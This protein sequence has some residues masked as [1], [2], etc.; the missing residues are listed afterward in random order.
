VVT[1]ES[2]A[3]KASQVKN[4][5]I[6][7]AVKLMFLHDEKKITE[8]SFNGLGFA[9]RRICSSLRNGALFYSL[10]RTY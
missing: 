8:D 4:D 2:G 1:K 7:V 3:K 10:R 6:K 5:I 9:F